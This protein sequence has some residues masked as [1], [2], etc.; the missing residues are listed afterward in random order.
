VSGIVSY[1]DDDFFGSG[2]VVTMENSNSLSAYLGLVISVIIYFLLYGTKSE[3]IVN[4]ILFLFALDLLFATKSIQGFVIIFI[5]IILLLIHKLFHYLK[6]RK[7]IIFSLALFFLLLIYGYE[8]I[9]S[10]LVLNGSVNQRISY[11]KLALEI[12]QDNFWVGVG[13]ENMR[14]YSILYRDLSLVIQEGVNTA[15]DRAHNIILDHYVSGGFFTGTFWLIF[16]TSITVLSISLYLR[17]LKGEA[18]FIYLGVIVIW[19]GYLFQSLISVSPSTLTFLGYAS[20]GI[21]AGAMYKNR[22][23]KVIN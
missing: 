1:R 2:A 12:W 22:N 9:S 21:V 8:R 23:S 20:A 13:I 6:S 18:E 16:I 4:S 5:S 7:V 10:W 15:P 11:W 3:K 17:I 19:I 14:S